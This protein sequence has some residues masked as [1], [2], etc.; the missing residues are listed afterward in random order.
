MIQL[1]LLPNIKAEYVKAQRTKRTV[2]TLA[3][4]VSAVS[5][6]IV[7]LLA[8]VA[9][10]AQQL[11][12][13]NVQDTISKNENAIKQE[14][15]LDKVLT[16]QNQLA[17]LTGLHDAKAVMSRLFT[18][19]QQTTPAAISISHYTVDN[20][21]L[22]WS[23]E[24]KAPSLELINKYVDTLKF[25]EIGASE[26]GQDSGQ[27]AFSEVVLTTFSKTDEGYT[28]SV[29]LKFDDQLFA[30][31]NPDIKLVVPNITTTRSQTQLPSADLFAPNPTDNQETQ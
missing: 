25:T 7:V 26:E 18:Y 1:N 31:Q 6:G 28:F 24:G 11:R 14:K 27:R 3:L 2:T 8:G 30:S 12:L 13:K 17:A 22:T 5:I 20:E 9:Y 19:L 23:V 4:I 16:I 29:N 21:G 10:G 15:D